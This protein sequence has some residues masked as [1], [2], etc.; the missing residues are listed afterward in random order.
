MIQKKSKI[1]FIGLGN[2]GLPMAYNLFKSGYHLCCYDISEQA[3]DAAKSRS[4]NVVLSPG[5]ALSHANVIFTMLPEGRH[6]AQCYL[7]HLFKHAQEGQIFI[8]CSTIDLTTV[9]K[10][11]QHALKKNVSIL[12]APVSGGI[13]GAE[14]ARLTIMVG[15][16]KTVFKQVKPLLNAM[17]AKIIHCGYLGT[18]QMAKI[19]NNMMLGIQMISVCEA[20]ALARKLGL[21]DEKLFEV[22]SSSSGQCWSL[23]SYCPVPGQVES[24]P[25]NADYKAGFNASLMLKDLKL[26]QTAA[27]DVAQ[28]TSLAQH[29]L[30]RYQAFVDQGYANLDFS[31]IFK[32]I[33]SDVENNIK[34]SHDD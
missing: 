3:R 23:T 25:S 21:S 15:G 19:C 31:A 16:D 9:K 22:S 27:R 26:S 13:T 20:F 17:G 8:D 5:E 28:K 29:A 18:G 24:S 4:L 2:M 12:D 14:K 30:E 10:L 32:Q 7:D 1:A 34:K 6:V 33:E 11:S